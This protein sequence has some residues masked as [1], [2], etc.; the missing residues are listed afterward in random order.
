MKT[1][2]TKLVIDSQT[3]PTSPPVT[4]KEIDFF[5]EHENGALN[6]QSSQSEPIPVTNGTSL[7]KAATP[8]RSI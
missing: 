6:L 3:E 5:R 2:G 7:N 8:G 1:Y 4:E